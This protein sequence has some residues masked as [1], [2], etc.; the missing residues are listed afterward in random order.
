MFRAM[1]TL[2]KISGMQKLIV[3]NVKI[4]YFDSRFKTSVIHYKLINKFLYV[5][6]NKYTQI[7][8][9]IN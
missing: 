1:Y 2:F 4:I 8:F 9:K 7:N 5:K 6:I 3:F